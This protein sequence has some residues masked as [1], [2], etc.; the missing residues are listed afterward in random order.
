MSLQGGGDGNG[1]IGLSPVELVLLI[2]ARSTPGVCPFHCHS[3][4][5]PSELS[6]PVELSL[7]P[8]LSPSTQS[9]VRS[10]LTLLAEP[11]LRSPGSSIYRKGWRTLPVSE[12][13]KRLPRGGDS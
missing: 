7:A 13:R 12:I 10:P 4:L 2:A 3:A 1:L 5:P 9:S 8:H 6:H 11:T